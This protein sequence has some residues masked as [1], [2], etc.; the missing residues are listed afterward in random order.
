ML[1]VLFCLVYPHKCSVGLNFGEYFGKALSLSLGFCLR[2]FFTLGV[3]CARIPSKNKMIFF[4]VFDSSC[5]RNLI[6]SY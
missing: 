2:K 3:L 6:N 5:F 1:L 4:L